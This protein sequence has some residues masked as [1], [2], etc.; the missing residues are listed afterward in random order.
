[1]KILLPTNLSKSSQIAAD[2]I[3][4]FF[5]QRATYCLLNSYP[6]NYR[7]GFY[8]SF[9]NYKPENA[10]VKM[11]Q[12]KRESK[13]LQSKYGAQA[14][15]TKAL[16]GDPVK[17]IFHTAEKEKINLIVVGYENFQNWNDGFKYRDNYSL[18]ESP[19]P[20]LLVPANYKPSMA[21]SI[22]YITD[23]S[24]TA[25]SESMIL[26]RF[27]ARFSKASI[28]LYCFQNKEQDNRLD[29][30]MIDKHL[31]GL[32]YSFQIIQSVDGG[33][34]KL[35]TELKKKDN[36]LV[37]FDFKKNASMVFDVVQTEVK[38]NSFVKPLLL[39]PRGFEENLLR[40]A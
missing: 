20:I 32:E 21:K 40:G 10:D 27:I 25:I 23:F 33:L 5:G 22:H 19:Y 31:D 26:I 2:F 4:S 14:I 7:S 15:S 39:M 9:N 6:F 24:N 36:S 8:D 17:D 34:E 13:R 35:M 3:V 38:N 16:Y 11:E 30:W 1:M 18:G 37:I 12:L 29:K 28:K